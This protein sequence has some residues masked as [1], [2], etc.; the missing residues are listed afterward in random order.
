MREVSLA[1]VEVADCRVFSG[2][3]AAL[4]EDICGAFREPL[5]HA[6]TGPNTTF[7]KAHKL[8][9]SFSRRPLRDA[10]DSPMTKMADAPPTG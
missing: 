10:V 4:S 3:P 5:L 9:L 7:S 8:H 1:R 6:G 2:A